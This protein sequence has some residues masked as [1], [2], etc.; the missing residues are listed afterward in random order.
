[1]ASTYTVQ[2]A[3]QYVRAFVKN[4]PVSDVQV[5]AADQVNAAIWRSYPWRWS[6]SALT[7]IPLVDA[8]QDY[9]SAPTNYFRLVRAR[10][11]RTDTT[12]DQALEPLDIVNKIEPG[13]QVMTPYAITLV[14]YEGH[15][16]KFRLSAP[17][18]VGSTDTWE[19]RGEYQKQ[20][21]KLGST[22]AVFPFPD[23]YFE[24]VTTGLLWKFY[25]LVGDPRAGTAQAN[26][27][28][29]AAYTGMLGKFMDEIYSM[30][31]DEGYAAGDLIAPSE[32]LM[33][34]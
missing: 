1:M 2:D 15:V 8:T 33:A 13:F 27:R 18:Q 5:I 4:I 9:G 3:V 12:P 14:A 21:T 25:D 6:M 31:S 29:G 26:K 23:Q 20:P 19:L 28:G 34:E 7:A 32:S 24:V 10:I 16:D 30:A 11:V 22:S 17:A